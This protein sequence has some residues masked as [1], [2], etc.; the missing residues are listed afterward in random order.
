[1]PRRSTTKQSSKRVTSRALAKN[2]KA[3][4]ATAK[5]SAAPQAPQ[6]RIVR[7]GAMLWR[8]I[9]KPFVWMWRRNRY[10]MS[11]RPHRSFRWTRKRDMPK[12]APLPSNIFFTSEV[13]G[14]IKRNWRS[15]LAFLLIYVLMFTVLAGMIN[16]DNYSAFTNSIKNA[17]SEVIAG[18]IGKSTEVLSAF[19]AIVTGQLN[20]SLSEVQQVYIATLGLFTWMSMVW[21]LRHRIKGVKVTVRDALYSS[22]A[23]LIATLVVALV[24]L[25]QLL[26]GA[27]GVVAYFSLLAMD[28]FNGGVESMLFAIAAIL[29]VV[30]SLYWVVGTL[31][32]LIV[33]TIPGTYPFRAL[34]LAGDVVIGRRTSMLVRMLWLAFVLVLIWAF[35]LVPFILLT[36]AL[37]WKWLP[38]VPLV[39]QLL[40]GFS[41]LFSATYV[42]LLYR[43]MI[44]EPAPKRSRK[45]V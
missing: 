39:A 23:P 10:F 35:V 13:I 17:G 14:V 38:I 30:L 16:Q 19:G 28:A 12:V 22:G 25:I 6:R 36:D 24:G 1:M 8:G 37:P 31:F 5:Q 7:F 4:N 15:Y 20:S 26:P 42:Y 9:K 43:R 2:T 34:S 33:V 11:R 32:A 45:A 3:V 27:I 40:A 29:L 41:I 44:D 18:N 21:F